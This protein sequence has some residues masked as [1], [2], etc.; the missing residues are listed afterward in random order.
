MANL[1]YPK[2]RKACVNGSANTDL[3]GGNVI[4]IMI[5][6]ADY[7]YSA[8]HEFYSDIPAGARVGIS[9]NLAGKTVSDAALFDANDIVISAVTGDPTEI[10]ALVINT[11]VEGTSRI[12]AYIDTGVTYTPNGNNVNVAWNAGG[13]IQF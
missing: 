3:I 1:V 8:T 6:G 10:V 7:T 11:G 13:I 12:V 5:D 9:G 2:Y 4:A